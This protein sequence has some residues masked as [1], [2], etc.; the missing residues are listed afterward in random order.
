MFPRFMFVLWPASV[1]LCGFYNFGTAAFTVFS[2]ANIVIFL[3]C[4]TKNADFKYCFFI[5]YACV[6]TVGLHLVQELRQ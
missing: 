1:S 5:K 2:L 3:F 6:S 4:F